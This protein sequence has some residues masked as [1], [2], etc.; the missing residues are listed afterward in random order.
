MPASLHLPCERTAVS[1][2]SSLFDGERHSKK[3]K[4]HTGPEVSS[5]AGPDFITATMV[6]T[7]PQLVFESRSTAKKN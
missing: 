3:V 5:D 7:R 1:T 6:G 2:S 4:V